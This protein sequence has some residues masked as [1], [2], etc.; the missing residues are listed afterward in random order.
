MLTA[1]PPSLAA[2]T[3]L[4]GLQAHENKL[5]SIPP[6]S[7]PATLET[8]FLHDNEPLV[9][10]PPTLVDCAA[11]RRVNVANLK[12]DEESA[13]VAESLKQIVLVASEGIYW[14]PDGGKLVATPP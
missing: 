8:L 4:V 11:L 5:E 14:G 7:W 2:L 9:S 1:L 10:L 6:S 13:E 12:L 3:G